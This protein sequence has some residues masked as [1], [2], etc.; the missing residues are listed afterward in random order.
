MTFTVKIIPDRLVEAYGNQTEV[1][2]I[3]NCNRA[4]VRKYIGDKE[5]KRHAVVNGV[6]MVHRGWDKGKDSDA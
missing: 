1:A 5:G 2:R 3:L 6:L 4:T